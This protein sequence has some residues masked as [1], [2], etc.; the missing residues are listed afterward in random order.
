MKFILSHLFFLFP[1]CIFSDVQILD[2]KLNN[3]NLNWSTVN[4]TVMG[5]VH[6][7]SGKQVLFLHRY[8]KAI[9][10]LKTTADLPQSDIMSEI[11][12][13]QMKAVFI[14]NLSEMEEL[15]N[16]ESARNLQAGQTTTMNL[17]LRMIKSCLYFYL[18]RILKLHGE[19]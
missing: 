14:L 11:R 16:L 15:I 8:L 12:I 10:H 3:R 1:I 13:F 17:K 5:G 6:L 9:F 4:D 7:P 18:F 2:S 19:D